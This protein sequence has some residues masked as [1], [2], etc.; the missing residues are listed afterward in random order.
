MCRAGDAQLLDPEGQPSR[1][2]PALWGALG[3][4]RVSV[5]HIRVWLHHRSAVV[6]GEARGWGTATVRCLPLLS[7]LQILAVACHYTKLVR[8]VHEVLPLCTAARTR[9][10]QSCVRLSAASQDIP[11]PEL[12]GDDDN[13][14][15]LEVPAAS[16][17]P[18]AEACLS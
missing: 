8:D 5:H 17:P 2:H 7:L 10:G 14:S 4:S 11:M 9:A 12:D 13:E 18:H 16:A 1:S 15:S 3:P 6:G